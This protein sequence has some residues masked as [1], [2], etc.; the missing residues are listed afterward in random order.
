VRALFVSQDK[1]LT[2]PHPDADPDGHFDLD[3][4]SIHFLTL[5]RI[6]LFIHA[7]P[8]PSPHEDDTNLLLLANRI[9]TSPG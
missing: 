4:V 5:M 3:P 2:S 1:L 6:L 8:D 9:S 7:D